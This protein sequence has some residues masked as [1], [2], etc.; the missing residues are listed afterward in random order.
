MHTSCSRYFDE[1][2]MKYFEDVK[3][4]DGER[5]RAPQIVLA[6]PSRQGHDV[7]VNN[8]NI[9][10]YPIIVIQPVDITEQPESWAI[11]SH[12]TRP[13]V[14]TINRAK[15]MHDG[16]E[17]MYVQYNYAIKFAALTQ[18]MYN[19][20]REKLMFKLKKHS[21]VKVFV[22]ASNTVIRTP[23]LIRN[24]SFSNGMNY[25]ELADTANRIFNGS[26]T[27]TLDGFITNE[28][29]ATRSIMKFSGV[30]NIIEPDSDEKISVIT[31]IYTEDGS[32]TEIN[33]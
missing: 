30:K 3:I 2:V 28:E 27:F 22:N 5:Y 12:V 18:E 16:V 9:P 14:L 25:D 21:Y 13:M 23:A 10:V 29:Y 15:K 6:L 7:V 31:T 17:I 24:V 1:A 19:I 8:E 33:G 4:H 26:V 11:K 32:S 20:I